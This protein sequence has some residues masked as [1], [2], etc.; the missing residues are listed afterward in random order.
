MNDDELRAALRGAD[1][2][3]SLP[4]ADRA[5]V[6]DHLEDAVTSTRPTPA[7]QAWDADGRRRAARRRRPWLVGMAVAV[8][9]AAAA[10][11]AV[12]VVLSRAPGLET[13][14]LTAEP[15]DPATA[16]CLPVPDLLPGV[17]T[18][19]AG[20]VT[21]VDGDRVVLEV[22]RAYRGE[23]GDRV[24]VDAPQQDGTSAALVGGFPFEVGGDYLVAATAG[25]VAVCGASG[26]ADSALQ[27]E[28][29]RTFG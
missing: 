22:E 13:T 4:P 27:S 10:V 5:W 12:P 24:V 7:A 8:G 28:Y 21:S 17:D 9:V 29:D 16:S 18:A 19:F 1:P 25:R 14:A 23:P 3:T 6:T 2:A 15:F 11:V 26:P 20:R